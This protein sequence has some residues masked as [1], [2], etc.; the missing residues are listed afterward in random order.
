MSEVPAPV[1]PEV[2]EILASA[3]TEEEKLNRLLP[4]LYPEL[5]RLASSYMR[6][7][8][9]THTLQP[10]A[11]VHEAFCKLIGQEAKWQNRAHFMGVAA[12]LMRRVLV[13]HARAKHADKRGGH[14]AHVD[15]EE[16]LPSID[17]AS[18]WGN[19]EIESRLGDLDEA[20]SKLAGFDARLAKLV[21]LRFFGGLSNEESAQVLD[22]S[23]ATVKRDWNLAKAWIY[24]EL[25]RD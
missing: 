21:E 24:R 13:D 10:T 17:A 12:Q 15:F 18:V 3:A 8:S 22:V 20:L 23:L 14:A 6:K 2:T 25:N 9:A 1:T 7:E 16:A 11:L 4:L 5:K 19:A